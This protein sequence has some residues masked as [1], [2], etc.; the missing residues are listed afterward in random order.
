MTAQR[1]TT[2][3]IAILGTD[4]VVEN[5]LA[6]L[7][8]GFGY[9][10]RL[11]EDPLAANTGEQLE[12]VDVVLLTPSLSEEDREGFLKAIEATTAVAHVPLLT[13][14][15]SRKEELNDRPGMVSW[16][17]PLEDLRQAIEA[18]LA[19]V[20]VPAEGEG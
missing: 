6:L 19:P 8:E 13:L 11:L 12:G 20:L 2:T 9:S 5:A 3:T 18:A 17:T 1:P 4:T 10:T 16:P 14:S 15:T 7:L